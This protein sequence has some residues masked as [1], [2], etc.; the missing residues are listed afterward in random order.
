MPS[1]PE[2]R[3]SL[4][5]TDQTAAAFRSALDNVEHINHSVR[6]ASRTFREFGL[7]L[8]T[9]E[10]V[11]WLGEAAKT[12]EVTDSQRKALD[13]A[14]ASMVRLNE[15][16]KTL[17]A[18]LM[19]E[20]APAIQNAAEWWQRLL[21]P[22]DEQKA[23]DGLD[24]IH[25]QVSDI[26]AELFRL[27]NGGQVGKSAWNRWFGDPEARAKE[28]RAQLDELLPKMRQMEAE[29]ERLRNAPAKASIKDLTGFDIAEIRS[30]K[31][32]AM[33]NFPTFD[34]I[35]DADRQKA[36]QIT[37]KMRTELEK[38]LDDWHEIQRLLA[39]GLI[40]PET[41]TR[42]RD[43]LLEPIEVTAKRLK[44]VKQ[45]VAKDGMEWA[46]S[47]G[48]GM[49]S[50][51]ADWLTDSEFNFRDF[52][53]RMS[54][55]FLSSAVFKGIGAMI[56][57]K[58]PGDSGGI[59]GAIF[60]GFKAEGGPVMAGRGYVVGERGPELFVPGT[61]GS[62]VPNG[63]GAAPIHIEQHLHFDVGLESVD[64]RIMQAA[65]PIS[66]A[67]ITAIA[68]AMNRPSMA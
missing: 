63:A 66:K 59:L 61:R 53:R 10:L 35:P 64:Q 19:S 27:Q 23:G 62:I 56:N 36:L 17:A 54:A 4:T 28:L 65:G 57:S 51:F 7:A 14:G 39:E 49:K 42:F 40:T 29:Q 30:L 37:E 26:S 50:A 38:Q 8:G 47:L 21:F 31:T 48:Y 44:E 3:I 18:S 5:A 52:L 58:Y 6:Q 25:K 11:Q 55:E 60:G 16:A 9:R 34:P 46:R 45:E 43:S 67:T 1:N 32:E 12:A 33:K 13:D 68:K 24:K 15:S 20:L 22:T 2:A 41:A